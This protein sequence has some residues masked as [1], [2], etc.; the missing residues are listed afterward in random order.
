MYPVQR[1][2]R[3]FCTIA[4]VWMY[5]WLTRKTQE[6]RV[7]YILINSKKGAMEQPFDTLA[8]EVLEEIISYLPCRQLA[9]MRQSGRR[10]RELSETAWKRCLKNVYGVF[11][12]ALGVLTAGELVTDI[13]GEEPEACD[14]LQVVSG[15][16][17][18]S[19]DA[20]YSF[21]WTGFLLLKTTENFPFAPDDPWKATADLQEAPGRVGDNWVHLYV[22]GS[23]KFPEDLAH[24]L[25]QLPPGAQIYGTSMEGNTLGSWARAVG[26]SEGNVSS[27]PEINK[28]IHTYLA[29]KLPEALRMY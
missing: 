24:L 2:L 28:R 22:I 23:E 10:N 16:H 3:A 14:Y 15:S 6:Y 17:V 21:C 19:V 13:E 12:E 9:R 25:L 29:D 8:P 5:K 1:G 11:L 20:V 26:A 4:L 27:D 7:I 18:V